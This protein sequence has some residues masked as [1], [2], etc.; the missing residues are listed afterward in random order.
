MKQV[1]IYRNDALECEQTLEQVVCRLICLP[2]QRHEIFH[3]NAWKEAM[4]IPSIQTAR[5][6]CKQGSRYFYSGPLLK[7]F[8]YAHEISFLNEHQEGI[9]QY[10]FLRTK[11]WKDASQIFAPIASE[12]AAHPLLSTDIFPSFPSQEHIPLDTLATWLCGDA[13]L[14]TGWIQVYFQCLCTTLKNQSAPSFF[15]P[16]FGR[17]HLRSRKSFSFSVSRKYPRRSRSSRCTVEGYKEIT[18]TPCPTLR[19]HIQK[20]EGAPERWRGEKQPRKNQKNWIQTDKKS[21]RRTFVAHMQGRLQTA[22]K[23]ITEEE[24]LSLHRNCAELLERFHVLLAELL[25]RK[26]IIGFGMIGV[27]K[28]FVVQEHKNKKPCSTEEMMVPT[29]HCVRLVLRQDYIQRHLQ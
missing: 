16:S 20:G 11:T 15:F 4:Q 9:H 25:I 8:L 10:L 23:N 7:G 28:T 12:I 5:N 17:F 18:F 14:G 27:L 13:R 1:F 3:E 2:D 24:T 22:V 26:N 6:N 29:H 19:H 21:C